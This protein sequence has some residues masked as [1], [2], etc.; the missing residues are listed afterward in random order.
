MKIKKHSQRWKNIVAKEIEIKKNC[1]PK[2]KWHCTN[3]NIKKYSK[4]C[5]CKNSKKPK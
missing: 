1:N 5:R 4:S 2:K 3:R